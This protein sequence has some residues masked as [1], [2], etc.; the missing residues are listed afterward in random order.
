MGFSISSAI[1]FLDLR[2]STQ[3]CTIF[4]C[5][6]H[7]AIPSPISFGDAT[8]AAFIGYCLVVGCLLW[9]FFCVFLNKICTARLWQKK[10]S[11]GIPV[12]ASVVLIYSFSRLI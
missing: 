1:K 5:V 4:G 2:I 11:G 3:G 6:G 12:R 8:I 9:S 7:F 10:S